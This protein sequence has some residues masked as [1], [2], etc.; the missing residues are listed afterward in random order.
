MNYV[1]AGLCQKGCLKN[2]LRVLD[3]ATGTIGARS[4]ITTA[5]AVRWPVVEGKGTMALQRTA[6]YVKREGYKFY[7]KRIWQAVNNSAAI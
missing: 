7:G 2:T 3:V 6:H 1:N 4:T 5:R